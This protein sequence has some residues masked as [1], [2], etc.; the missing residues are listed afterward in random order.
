MRKLITALFITTMICSL[1]YG[2][3]KVIKLTTPDKTRGKTV[4]QALADR[5]SEREFKDQALSQRDLSDLLWA[6]VGVNRPDGKRTSPTAM[7][8]QEITVYAVLP[9]GAY[10]YEADKHQ[11]TLIKAGD[12]R[13]AVAGQQ[14]FVTKAP[15]SLEIVSDT[16]QFGGDSKTYAWVD[17]GI[18]SQNINIFCAGVGLATVPRSSMDVKRLTEVLNLKDGEVPVLNNPV[19]YPIGN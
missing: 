9:E 17:A 18:V 10:K 7:N 8:K 12:F 14:D 4:M 19:G 15:V 2:Q 16:K 1:S 13:A 3:E 6:A 5:K 11:L